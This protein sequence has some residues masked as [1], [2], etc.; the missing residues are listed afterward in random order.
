[1]CNA[2][3]DC[4][5]NSISVLQADNHTAPTALGNGPTIVE[6]QVDIVVD[7]I[8]KMRDE[9]IK[10]LDAMQEAAQAWADDLAATSKMTLLED[11]NSWYMGANIPGKKREMLNYLKGLVVY[12]KSCRDAMPN[13]DGFVVEMES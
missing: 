6:V 7:M 5:Q 4:T 12:E 1:M 10:Y 11:A 9:N 8:K 13:W 2:Q 3:V